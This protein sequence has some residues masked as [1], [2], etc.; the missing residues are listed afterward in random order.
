VE[1]YSPKVYATNKLAQTDNENLKM[2]LVAMLNY[3]AAAQ[4]F[5]GYKTDALMNADLTQ[6]QKALVDDYSES[7]IAALAAV[8]AAK[9][10]E[11]AATQGFGRKNASVSFDGSLDVNFYF[12]ASQTLA[13]G[14]VTFYAWDSDSYLNSDVL[15]AENASYT[16]AMELNDSGRHWAEVS[17]IAAKEINQTFYVCGV[18]E[19][20]GQRCST[21]VIAYSLGQYCKNLAG[22]DASSMQ[23]LAAAT[24]VYGY[25][26]DNYFA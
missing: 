13:E 15:T 8:D 10:G 17:D 25:Y 21:G 26:A 9:V 20:D 4:E 5:F 1:A 19:V 22:K 11:F 16:A 14:A 3:G 24:A 2:L 6:E 12:T 7:M 18:Y 23:A